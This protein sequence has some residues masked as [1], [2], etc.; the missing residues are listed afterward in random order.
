MKTSNFRHYTGD[1]GI[2]ICARPPINW[3]GLQ[4]LSLAPDIQLLHEFKNGQINKEQ[5][6]KLYRENVLA[7]LNPKEI[8]DALKNM[9]LLCWEEPIFNRNGKIIN[10]GK[11]FCHRHI[12][13]QWIYDEL[14]IEIEEWQPDKDNNLTHKLLF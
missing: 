10:E 13:S 2:S 7:R 3:T 14:K 9:V 8:Y 11:G 1:M 5:Y 12:V 6:E 4:F